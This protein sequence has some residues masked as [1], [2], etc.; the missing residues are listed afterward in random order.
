MRGLFC[1][2]MAHISFS[3]SLAFYGVSCYNV[4]NA[5]TL[6]EESKVKLR[7]VKASPCCNTTVF[8][9]DEV[10]R[11]AYAAV[12]GLVMETEYLAAEQVGFLSPSEDGAALLHLSMSGGEFCGNAM[13]AL[14][15]WAVKEGLARPSQEFFLTC[16]GIDKPLQH[17]VESVLA[18]R[19]DVR[20]KMPAALAIRPV[21]MEA[22]GQKFFGTLVTFP[23]I[24]HFCF[25]TTSL[26]D[27]V[28]Y[29]ALLTAVAKTSGA[30]AYGVVPYW[31]QGSEAWRIH[32]YIGVAATGS[33]V[34]EKACGSGSLA[35]AL[36]LSETA[37]SGRLRILQPGGMITADPED[38]SI[39]TTVYFPCEGCLWVPDGMI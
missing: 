22:A 28:P 38:P 36:A 29:D 25:E 27:R 8:I 19:F 21:V 1:L 11:A 34:Y 35:L 7:F 23:G 2:Q 26:P 4:F 20:G 33:R 16:S 15:A 39:S 13:L 32:P 6:T 18:G 17:T 9:L 3:W 14:G 5:N 12:A 10:P 31:R 37:G 24:V 30:A